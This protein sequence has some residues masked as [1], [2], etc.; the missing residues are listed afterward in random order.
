MAITNYTPGEDVI[1]HH[2]ANVAA[3]AFPMA[4]VVLH[5]PEV[6]TVVVG[7]LGII[8]YGILIGEKI[9]GWRAQFLQ[10]QASSR[11]VVERLK[12]EQTQKPPEHYLDK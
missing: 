8:W 7:I 2:A 10:I 1:A 11:T 3:I 9:A 12:D 4:S 6:V 5:L